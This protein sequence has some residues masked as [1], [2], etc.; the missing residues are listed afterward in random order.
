M[1]THKSFAS[2]YLLIIAMAVCLLVVLMGFKSLEDVY[3]PT[4]HT[5]TI[6]KMKFN[7]ADIIVRKGDTV[8]WINKDF[9]QHDVTELTSKKWTS[10]PLDQGQSFSKVI[11]ED[12]KYYCDLH[13][14]MKGTI[15]IAK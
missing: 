4:R 2:K 10:K 5:V 11:N 14:V 3:K 8:V 7:P 15:T 12:V 6:V 9:Y 1:Q 13:K